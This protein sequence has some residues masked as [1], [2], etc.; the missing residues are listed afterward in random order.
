MAATYQPHSA[1]AALLPPT[2]YW[3]GFL[4]FTVAA[5]V[6]RHAS[7]PAYAL[8]RSGAGQAL[9]RLEQLPGGTKIDHGTGWDEEAGLQRGGCLVCVLRLEID[10]CA[11]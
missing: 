7:Q 11:I 9:L 10:A 2:A 4:G 8:L 6:P 1:A 3:N 5:E